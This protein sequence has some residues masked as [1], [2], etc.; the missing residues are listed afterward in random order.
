MLSLLRL[1]RKQK[2]IQSISNSH[3]SLSF[4]LIWN[5][6]DKYV[7]SLCIS[8]ENHTRFQTKVGK[9]YTGFQL[10]QNG[11]KTLPDGRNVPT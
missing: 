3:I 10:D 2:N 11:A 8:L 7:H 1:E 6:N 9:V 5:W 4:L